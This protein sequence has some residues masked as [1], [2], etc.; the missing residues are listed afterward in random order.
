VVIDHG[1]VGAGK[2]LFSLYAH[3]GGGDGSTGTKNDCTITKADGSPAYGDW[4]E[5]GIHEGLRV[6][7]GALLGYQGA[8]GAATGVHLHFEVMSYRASAYTG[9]RSQFNP[10]ACIGGQNTV[11]YVYSALATGNACP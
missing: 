10:T 11:G 2:H 6:G 7:R 5:P 4:I 9:L 1:D 3:M 8:S